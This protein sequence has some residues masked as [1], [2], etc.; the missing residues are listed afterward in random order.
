MLW[1]AAA[2]SDIGTW[3]QLIVVGSLVAATTGSAVQTGLVALA[4]FA[5]QGLA[6]PVGGLL[7]DRFER[8][9]VFASCLLVQALITTGLAV[10]L[11]AGVRTPGVL[12]LLILL[13]SA[14]GAMGSPAYAAMIPDLVPKE[15][16]MA[17]VSLG[18][19]SWNAGRVVGPLLGT[20]LEV[21]VGPSLTIAFNAAT[22]IVL[23]VTVSAVR[24]TFHPQRSG[25]S[26]VERLVGGWRAL[27]RAP[28]CWHSVV[29]L[30]LF[31]LTVV[32]FMGLIPIYARSVF[33]GGTALT[34]LMSSAQGIGAIAGGLLV[35]ALSSRLSRSYLLERIVIVEIVALALYAVAPDAW[36]VVPMAL[37]LGAGS[38][39]LFITCSAILQR[40]AP[41][42][43][44]GRVMA[45]NQAFMGLSYGV[46][47]LTIGSLGDAT[48]LRVAFGTGSLLLL[49]GFV[50]LT[51]RSRNWRAALD[52]TPNVTESTA[53]SSSRS[54][55]A[56]SSPVS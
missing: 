6:S 46:G 12:T 45:T 7:A 34:G 25:G 3:V 28:G 4:T 41:D 27:R 55:L 21:A 53:G 32:P 16:L 44:R 9:R 54:T 13:S 17:M 18:V 24:R 51:R 43:S 39:G 11:G 10:V 22:F 47:I 56:G 36:A 1:L 5:P 33:G 52:G 50:A 42:H 19:Y 31:N 2:V 14:A 23:A 38:S 49:V 37:F 15:E 20:A 30:V 48:N 8:R 40:D 26:I 29:I 35:T